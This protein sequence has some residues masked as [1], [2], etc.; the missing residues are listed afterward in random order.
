MAVQG[1]V[2]KA[3][4][5]LIGLLVEV[6]P[7]DIIILGQPYYLIVTIVIGTLFFARYAEAIY[8]WDLNLVYGSQFKKLDELIA[9]MEDLR[10]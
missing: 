10:K 8:H 9:D 5:K 7:T 1:V 2:S 6:L 4:Q 3:G